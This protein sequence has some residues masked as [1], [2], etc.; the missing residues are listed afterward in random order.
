M[1]EEK[2]ESECPSRTDDALAMLYLQD[3]HA[4]QSMP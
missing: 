2:N 1:V 3:V 4:L